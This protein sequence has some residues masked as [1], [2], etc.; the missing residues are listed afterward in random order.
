MGS[1]WKKRRNP[2]Q[3]P[4]LASS[5]PGQSVSMYLSQIAILCFPP[6][7]LLLCKWPSAAA[8]YCMSSESSN[9]P[10]F[11]QVRT[12]GCLRSSVALGLSVGSLWRHLRRKSLP[13]WERCSGMGGCD[14]VV[15]MW[16]DA[17]TSWNCW[18]QGGLPVA[19]SIRVQPTHQISACQLWPVWRMTSGA[20]QQWVPFMDLASEMVASLTTFLDAPKSA[21][22]IHP[23][24]STRMFTPL[25]DVMLP[26]GNP[27]G[28][29]SSVY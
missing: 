24:L 5:C 13:W 11:S 4:Q 8:W 3:A 10:W 15:P 16:N 29:C 7:C 28:Q 1:L 26:I 6:I 23:L 27:C 9:P 19:I 2:C 25:I 18:L 12:K 22:L 14:F 20:I 17:A 21:S